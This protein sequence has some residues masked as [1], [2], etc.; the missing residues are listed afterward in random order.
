MVVEEE[1]EE[2]EEEEDGGGAG[3]NLLLTEPLHLTSS[4]NRL[5]FRSHYWN[6]LGIS[7]KFYQAYISTLCAWKA[8]E[9]LERSP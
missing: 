3:G 2:E 1:E 9:S 7:D 8:K 6:S 5:R 4:M